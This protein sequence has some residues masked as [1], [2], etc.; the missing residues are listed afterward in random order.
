M[1]Q[2][3]YDIDE[4]KLQAGKTMYF[5]KLIVAIVLAVGL[6]I[7]ALSFYVLMLS[8][9]LLVQ[10]NQ[11]KLQSLL[12]IGY[13]V[14]RVALP[15]QCLT[16]GVNLLVFLCALAATLFVRGLYLEHLWRM[17]PTMQEGSLWLMLSFGTVLL[18]LV[19]VL[20]ILAVYRKVKQVW[21]HS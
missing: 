3:G 14:S 17:F 10:K 7:S 2:K 5:L 8:I 16:L 18:I 4:D 11:E 20:N 12:L 21:R 6:L 9:F 19:S 15:Y 13:S 1:K